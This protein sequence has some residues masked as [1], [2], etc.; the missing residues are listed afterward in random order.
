MLDQLINLVKENAGQAILNNAAIPAERKEEAVQVAGDS[1]IG[2]L[3]QALSQGNVMDVVNMFAGRSSNLQENPVTNQISGSLINQ[4]ASKFGLSN[5][6]ASGIAGSLIPTVLGQLIK[7]TNDPNDNG[8]NVQ[9][10]F[11]QLSGGKTSG[12]NVGA[13]ISKLSSG[14]DQDG[15]GDVDMQ[16]LMSM[17][18]GSGSGGGG[19]LFDKVKNMFK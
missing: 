14:L 17:F 4:M 3:Q 15:D 8:F 2:G 7:R 18:A 19:G 10:I 13:I 16:D 12:L 9:D 5:S 6:Q 1:V 11:N